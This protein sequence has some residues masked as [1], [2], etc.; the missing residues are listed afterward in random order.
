MRAGRTLKSM[1]LRPLIV[2]AAVA[3]FFA[4]LARKRLE[5]TKPTESWEPVT[6]L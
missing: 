2:I 1:K 4:A 3:A 5:E 6:Y